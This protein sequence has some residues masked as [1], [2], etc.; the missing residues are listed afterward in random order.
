[1]GRELKRVALDFEWPLDTVWKGFVN[2][3]R[4]DECPNCKNGYSAEMTVL[5]DKW[6]GQTEFHPEERGSIPYTTKDQAIIDVAKRNLSRSPFYY[7]TSSYALELEAQRLCDLFNGMWHHH[8]NQDDVDALIKEGRLHDFTHHYVDGSGWVENDPPTHP[9]A[10]EVNDWAIQGMGH[11]SINEWIVTKAECAR[12]GLPH[13]CEYCHGTG[14]FWKTP[15]LKAQSDAWKDYE[16]P[17][18]EGYQI[19]ET[20]SEGSPISPVFATPEELAE[21]MS[22]TT[23]GAD[24]GSSYETWM[25]FIQGPG[26]APSMIV[27]GGKMYMGQEFVNLPHDEK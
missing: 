9:T 4:A 3:F 18:G 17:A 21:H 19:W 16:P 11:D 5:R 2:P 10:K 22:H 24:T 6:Y 12:L 23:W 20:V 27:Q 26:W 13:D 14:E 7:G 25:K 15:E 1:M 8:L